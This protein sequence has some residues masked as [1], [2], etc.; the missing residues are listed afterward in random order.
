MHNLNMQVNVLVQPCD[1]HPCPPTDDDMMLA[2]LSS[3][4]VNDK[5]SA[6]VQ[7]GDLE[8]GIG[9]HPESSVVTITK[10][11]LLMMAEQ[12]D[13][14]DEEIEDIKQESDAYRF[15]IQMALSLPNPR[16][17]LQE[18]VPAALCKVLLESW[19]Q[20]HTKHL[21]P[22]AVSAHWRVAEES[23]LVLADGR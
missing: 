10:S 11:D 13:Y 5:M 20:A 17:S 6:H 1:R 4:A 8:P 21:L 15:Q 3:I 18:D 9:L 23:G 22:I 16:L 12:C 19:N 2:L 14:C 7:R